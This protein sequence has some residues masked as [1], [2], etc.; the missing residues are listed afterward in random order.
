MIFEQSLS[1]HL[2][3]YDMSRTSKKSLYKS[4]KATKSN[5][6]PAIPLI[7][8]GIAVDEAL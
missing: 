3:S 6:H 2:R 8:S 4:S 7:I 5:K 1:T